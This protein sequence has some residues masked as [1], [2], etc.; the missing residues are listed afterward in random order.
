MLYGSEILICLV[1]LLACIISMQH[2]Y[3]I[4]MD[5]MFPVNKFQVLEI[6]GFPL[7]AD[8][9]NSLLIFEVSSQFLSNKLEWI[10]KRMN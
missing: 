8:F 7:Y 1:D 9:I 2:C 6:I 4:R 10:T 3:A 5:V